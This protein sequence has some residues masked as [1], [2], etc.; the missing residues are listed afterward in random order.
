[1]TSLRRQLR[2]AGPLWPVLGLF[3][4]DAAAGMAIFPP[5]DLPDEDAHFH[6]AQWVATHGRLP[7]MS[8]DRGVGHEADRVRVANNPPLYY[9]MVAPIVG[10]DL[11]P[12]KGKVAHYEERTGT[13]Y[14][15]PTELKVNYVRR[16]HI[17]RALG[18]AVGAAGIVLMYA[19]GRRLFPWSPW[20]AALPAVL[21][22]LNPKIVQFALAVNP[23]ILGSVLA[24]ALVGLG[25]YRATSE[26]VGRGFPWVLGALAGLALLVRVNLVA[27]LAYVGTLWIFDLARSGVTRRLAREV[28]V[29]ALTAAAVA[30]WWYGRNGLVYGDLFGIESVVSNW[31]SMRGG[32]AKPLEAFGWGELARLARDSIRSSWIWALAPLGAGLAG[33]ALWWRRMRRGGGERLRPVASLYAACLASLALAAVLLAAYFAR[34][35]HVQGRYLLVASAPMA[36]FAAMGLLH[37][38]RHRARALTLA[39]LLVLQGINMAALWKHYRYHRLGEAPTAGVSSRFEIR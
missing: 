24:A 13:M 37:L 9:L 18:I 8:P 16:V 31:N 34:T 22:G 28:G 2:A 15:G 23:E 6:Y 39:S 5:W 14:A 1:M 17:C 10:S 30:G 27:M 25:V 29:T 35:S 11:P 38:F 19:A 3:V 32:G 4:A 7:P 20:A 33:L 21:F 12:I 26:G 36:L